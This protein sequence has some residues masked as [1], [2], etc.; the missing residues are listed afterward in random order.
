M[1]MKSLVA[2][3]ALGSALAVSMVSTANAVTLNPGNT[4]TD[5]ILSNSAADGGVS[6]LQLGPYFFG[7][8]FQSADAAGKAIFKFKNTLSTTTDIAVAIG[9]ILQ[10]SGGFFTG[11]VTVKWLEGGALQSV[12]Q[13]VTGVYN[14]SQTLLAGQVGTLK[15][16]FGDPVS[17]GQ[18]S[19]AFTVD[20]AS[21]VS[22]IPLPPAA[23]LLISGL[24]GIGVLSRRRRSKA[25]AV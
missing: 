12:A 24:A 25:E 9:T 15:I 13:G 8:A 16:I 7:A 11:G 18:G 23:L 2:G 22:P 6:D 3:L 21:T 14:I 10:G 5:P 17:K 4:I 20:V 19:A 1:K